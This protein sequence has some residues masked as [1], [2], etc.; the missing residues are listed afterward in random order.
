MSAHTPGPWEAVLPNDPR[1]QP[2]PYYCGLVSLVSHDPSISIVASDG[3]VESGAWEANARLIA[4]APDL[5]ESL[6]S[7][8]AAIEPGGF[9]L[10]DLRGEMDD[11]NAALKKARGES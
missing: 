9:S 4:A 10:E 8:L 7:L 6:T 2:V 5:L 1:G 11:A 3:Y